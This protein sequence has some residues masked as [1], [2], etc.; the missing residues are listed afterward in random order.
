MTMIEYRTVGTYMGSRDK[1]PA[2]VRAAA[3]IRG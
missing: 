2:A 1:R 3:I